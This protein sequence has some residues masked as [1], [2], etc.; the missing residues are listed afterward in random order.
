MSQRTPLEQWAAEMSAA[1]TT[2]ATYYRTAGIVTLGQTLHSSI[3]PE[4]PQHVHTARNILLNT[5]TK[6]QQAIIEPGEYL[7]RLAVNSQYLACLQWL[8]HF[9]VLSCIP[10][11]GSVLYSE[12]AQISLVPESQLRRNARM[13]M[14]SNFLCEPKPG[15][16]AHTAL[17]AHFVTNPALCDSAMFLADVVKPAMAKCVEAT[18][19]FG[20]T[21]QKNQT[22]LNIAI[23]NKMAFGDY[24]AQTPKLRRQ[25]SAYMRTVAT[26]D[27]MCGDQ[28]VEAFD[29]ASLRDATVVDVDAQDYSAAIALATRFSLLHVVVQAAPDVLVT[30]RHSLFNC[31]ESV[32]ARISSYSHNVFA[33]Q[34]IKGDVYL[35]RRLAHDTPPAEVSAILHNQLA[36]LKTCHRARVM[37]AVAVLPPS[38]SE[39]AHDEA[40]LR[41]RDLTWMHLANGRERDVQDVEELLAQASDCDGRFVVKSRTKLPRCTVSAFETMY[42]PNGMEEA[43]ILGVQGQ[44]C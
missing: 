10:L 24:L 34:L 17:S 31:P 30:S 16:L 5:T 8:C 36:P 35:I 1:A 27:E 33:P 11:D 43:Q 39:D 29:W 21:D 18:E 19:R 9:H 41:M 25:F 42:Q 38:G 28:L 2:L 6:V 14:T 26:N 4:A 3:P 32:R 44:V 13:M 12:I 22:A 20:A 40:L 15:E 37:L 7:Q 23:N